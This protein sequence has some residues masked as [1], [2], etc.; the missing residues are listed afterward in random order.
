MTRLW[1]VRHA[2][3]GAPGLC[4]WTDAPADLSDT[5]TLAR[6]SARLPAAALLLSS[7]LT[8]AAATAGALVT[9][10]RRTLPPDPRWREIHFGDWEGLAPA[11]LDPALSRAFWDGQA[12]APGGEGWGDLSSRVAAAMDALPATADIIVVAHLG[13]ILAAWA[14]AAGCGPMQALAHPV[15]PLSLTRL[16]RTAAGWYPGGPVGVA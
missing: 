14:R 6:L 12:T 2:P 7:D 1:L 5:A 4:G 10:G 3:T 13:A 16:D 9:P 11:T 15:P 8:R